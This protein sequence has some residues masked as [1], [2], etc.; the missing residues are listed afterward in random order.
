[1]RASLAYKLLQCP[2]ERHAARGRRTRSS[3][4]V[5][6]CRRQ[7]NSCIGICISTSIQCTSSGARARAPSERGED[8]DTALE[9]RLLLEVVDV[10]GVQA[11]E[12]A[13]LVERFEEVVEGRG[14]RGGGQV[15]ELCNHFVEQG[16]ALWYLVGGE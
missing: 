4:R 8:G 6:T 15:G 10:L 2:V 9:P 1:M 3:S 11:Q 16:G 7:A 12:L 14:A 13:A 5:R